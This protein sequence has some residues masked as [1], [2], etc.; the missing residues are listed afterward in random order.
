MA[1]K[2]YAE[3]VRDENASVAKKGRLLN[4]LL[5]VLGSMTVLLLILNVKL[6]SEVRSDPQALEINESYQASWDADAV[7]LL[8]TWTPTERTT[9]W[10]LREFIKALR[11][12]PLED[13]SDES[14]RLRFLGFG[15][16]HALESQIIADYLSVHPQTGTVSTYIEIPDDDI[17]MTKQGPYKWTVAWVE[18]EYDLKTKE[19]RSKTTYDGVFELGC[20]TAGREIDLKYDPAG[21]YVTYY[22]YDIRKER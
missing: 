5:M 18:R 7:R 4:L 8:E 20:Y 22:D 14:S 13:D 9:K 10:F 2:H 12:R 15:S 17:V 3:I 6:G 19:F 11:E 21:L 16:I 1:E